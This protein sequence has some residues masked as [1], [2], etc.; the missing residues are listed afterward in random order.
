[1]PYLLLKS[2]LLQTCDYR[3]IDISRFAIP[4]CEDA[5]KTQRNLLHFRQQ[6]AKKEEASEIAA[7]D[8]VTLSCVSENR[9]FQK[10]HLTIRIGLGLY[11]EELEEKLV[12]MCIG[13]ERAMHVGEDAVTVT[14]EKIV[15]ECLPEINDK[16]AQQCGITGVHT[17]ED[18]VTYCRYQQYDR[19]LEDPADDAFAYLA[20]KV[21]EDSVFTLDAEE[22]DCARSMT[23]RSFESNS[24]FGGR[25]PDEIPEEEFT[26]LFGTDKQTLLESMQAVGKSNL[27]VAVLGQ[28]MK[29][30]EGGLLT[31][32]DYEAYLNKRAVASGHSV[33]EMKRKHPLT[34]YLLETYS[35]FYMDTIE[36]YV[37]QKLK[38]VGEWKHRFG[39][40]S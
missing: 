10:T 23:M 39:Q 8:I 1:M 34:E 27:Q 26:A 7:H 29:E 16:L 35:A 3:S 13:E 15:R 37:F 6:F 32:Q 11:S 33:E 9:K 2:K 21:M 30:K 31:G 40:G 17:A 22:L 19:M 12:G 25:K 14:V 4:L 18:I 20:G 36:A 24:A 28:V 5:A 38:E